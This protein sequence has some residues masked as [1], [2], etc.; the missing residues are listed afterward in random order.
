MPAG[1]RHFVKEL[2]KSKQ[3]NPSDSFPYYFLC[4]N[5]YL[6]LKKKKKA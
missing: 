1:N 4:Y 2:F 3:E 5:E 6:R